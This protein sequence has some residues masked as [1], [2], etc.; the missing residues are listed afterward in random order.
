MAIKTYSV[1]S[2]LSPRELFRIQ[3]E[4]PESGDPQEV[5]EACQQ[6]VLRVLKFEEVG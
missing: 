4:V 2:T 6:K 3:V 1:R 5:E